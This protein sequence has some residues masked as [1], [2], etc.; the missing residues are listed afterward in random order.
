MAPPRTSA[1]ACAAAASPP[2]SNP[3]TAPEPAPVYASSM[4]T[5]VPIIP[6]PNPDNIKRRFKHPT[7]STIEN[8]PDYE[9]MCVVREELFC[10]AIAIKS[11]FGGR[12]MATSDTCNDPPSITRR[13][14]NHGQSQ[15]LEGCNPPSQTG[16][17]TT[18]RRERSRS[19]STARH[20]SRSPS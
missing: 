13:R 20:T 15:H 10:S 2:L 19:S 6:D 9:Q 12:D 14:S 4:D 18:K 1:T 16:Q 8:E 17:P 11:M 3:A 7:L 5:Y